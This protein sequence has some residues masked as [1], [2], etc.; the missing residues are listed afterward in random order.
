[1]IGCYSDQSKDF[2]TSGNGA[3]QALGTCEALWE[4]GLEPDALF[5][6]L[7]QCLMNALERD[8]GSGWGGFVYIIEKDKV[9]LSELKMRMD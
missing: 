1:M 8:A 4:P 6:T 5:E 7:S 9:T 3:E 2:A